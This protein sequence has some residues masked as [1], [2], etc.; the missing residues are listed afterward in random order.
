MSEL[1]LSDSFDTCTPAN[2]RGAGIAS[3]VEVLRHLPQREMPVTHRF[4]PG[5]YLREIFMPADTI[6]IGHVHK[7]CHF[8]VILSGR[9]IVDMGGTEQIIGAGDVFES[10][11]GVQKCLYILE[12]CR[13][14]TIHAN[15]SN[16]RD[17]VKIE[18]SLV[19]LDPD[20]LQAKGPLTLDE[21]RHSLV[22]SIPEQTT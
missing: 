10:G 13:W 18:E 1:A 5:V 20:Y 22:K 21:F 6:V 7:T 16:E 2:P 4:S 15:P 9:A 17:V 19:S 3:L 8:N 14:V 12:D 11:A